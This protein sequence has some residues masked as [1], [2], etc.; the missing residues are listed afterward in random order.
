MMRDNFLN[1]K[2]VTLVREILPKKY[3]RY[4]LLD[5]QYGYIR[6]SHF[7]K[8]TDAAFGQAAEDLNRN[9]H[10]NLKGLILDL[11][12][13]PGGLLDQAVR[14]ADRLIES[15]LIASVEGNNEYKRM[16]F[17]AQRERTLPPYPL[18]VMANKATGAG[19][20]IV[21]GALQDHQR[22]IIIGDQTLGEATIQTIFPLRKGYV[23]RLTT[24][25]WRTPN[26]HQIEKK[27]IVPELYIIS[28]KEA[29]SSSLRSDQAKI[30]ID[31]SEKD[32][33]LRIA[34]EILKR[35][36]SR[37]F[38]D[39]MAASREVCDIEQR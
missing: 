27:G 38:A 35:T 5:G 2:D 4:E 8:E 28:E 37:E 3:V 13:N 32:T 29:S 22:A 16:M 34:L 39:L 10:N 9:S 11:R 23:L 31:R 6:I 20:E 1:P 19:S 33:A 12:Y 14:V 36:K 26:G 15:G 25:V 7:D 24:A 30:M 17:R 18:V 21:V